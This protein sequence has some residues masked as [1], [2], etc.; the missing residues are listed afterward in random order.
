MLLRDLFLGGF[1]GWKIVYVCRWFFDGFGE[2]EEG[3]ESNRG[4][5]GGEGGGGIC[6]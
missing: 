3:N 4:R 1:Y 6:V 2:E 5:E